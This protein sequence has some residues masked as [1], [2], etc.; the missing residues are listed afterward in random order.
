M[1]SSAPSSPSPDPSAVLACEAQKRL[2]QALIDRYGSAAAKGIAAEIYSICFRFLPPKTES[3]SPVP[4]KTE[5]Q[6]LAA[7]MLRAGVELITP[8]QPGRDSR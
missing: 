3:P 6:R 4:A 8:L 7:L 5:A 1:S 2:A